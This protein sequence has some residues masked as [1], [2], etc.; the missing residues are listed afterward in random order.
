MQA[1]QAAQPITFFP[2]KKTSLAPSRPTKPHDRYY[3]YHSL[4][5]DGLHANML[6][7]SAL[8]Q[9]SVDSYAVQEQKQQQVEARVGTSRYLLNIRHLA[10]TPL[11]K[12]L[13]RKTH[14]R[15]QKM[16]KST[17]PIA[18][19]FQDDSKMVMANSEQDAHVDLSLRAGVTHC[20]AR[21]WDTQQRAPALNL[22]LRTFTVIKSTRDELVCESHI[23]EDVIFRTG[24]SGMSL[25]G[26]YVVCLNH[27]DMSD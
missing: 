11:H 3:E 2:L 4:V 6:P 13:L 21:S 16:A 26:N 8:L 17:H 27:S 10:Q 15:R 5:R 12:R 25:C 7:S 18:N 1:K 20:Y 9:A 19:P 14:I 23:G 22:P 24:H